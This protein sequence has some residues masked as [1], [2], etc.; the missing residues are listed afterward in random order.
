MDY[1]IAVVAGV[2]MM[3]F[4]GLERRAGGRTAYLLRILGNLPFL[5]LVILAWV[6]RFSYEALMI[7]VVFVVVVSVV[8]LVLDER[9]KRRV[10]S[11][12]QDS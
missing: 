9:R 12:Q 4:F 1:L 5:A 3:P 11:S 6:G 8:G 7:D 10:R 2:W